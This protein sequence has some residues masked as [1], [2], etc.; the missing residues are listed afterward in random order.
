MPRLKKTRRV[1]LVALSVAIST[2]AYW[3]LFGWKSTPGPLLGSTATATRF[4]GRV[5]RLKCDLNGDGQT[6]EVWTFSWREPL[7]H[8]QPTQIVSDQNF[9]GRWD[10]WITPE[11]GPSDSFPLRRYRADTTGDGHPDIEF[12]EADPRVA[13]Q[14]L[15]ESRG[16]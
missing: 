11:E 15:V 9:D 8:A 1:I 5:T 3:W 2:L 7:G 12:V 10:T 13:R 4:F 6:D 14:R 16:Y